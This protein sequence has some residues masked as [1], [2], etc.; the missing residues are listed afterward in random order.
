MNTFNVQA[1]V[2]PVL[3]GGVLACAVGLPRAQAQSPETCPPA[4][5]ER[6]EEALS[7]YQAGATSV[8]AERWEEALPALEQAGRLDP[9][10]VLAHYA[11]GQA[12]MALKR[13]REAVEAYLDGREAFR[14]ASTLSEAE[15]AEARKRLER[16]IAEVREALRSL[17]SSRHVEQ[18]VLERG[19]PGS[20]APRPGTGSSRAHV[21]EQQL[22]ELERWQKGD[23]TRPPALLSLALGNAYF[24]SGSLPDAEREFRAALL[25][26]PGSGDAHNNLAVVLMLTGRA[27][28]A[29]SEVRLAEKAGVPVNPRLLEEIRKRR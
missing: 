12:L 14:C 7:L 29:A 11:R 22:H 24:Q 6:R 2:N 9:R 28:E 16:E 26:D 13:Y 17:E 23:V 27:E 8:L 18:S 1:V 10:L 5:A 3:L 25:A 20:D 15:Q 19:M 21:L 4:A